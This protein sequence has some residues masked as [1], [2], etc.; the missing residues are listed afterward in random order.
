ME[1]V[2]LG[3]ALI[4]HFVNGE[5]VL[6]YSLPQIGGGVVEN[7]DPQAKRDGEVLTGGYLALQ[8]ESHPLDVRKIELLN[9]S[10]CMD[11]KNA[12]YRSY[13]VHSDPTACK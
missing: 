4:T 7:F 3:D 12:N 1:L 8:S 13:F 10:G 2:V 5:K 9:L 6:E 11:P